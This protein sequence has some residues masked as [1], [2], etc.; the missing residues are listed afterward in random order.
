MGQCSGSMFA[1]TAAIALGATV[2]VLAGLFLGNLIPSSI[3][4]PSAELAN[5]HLKQFVFYHLWHWLPTLAYTVAAAL[6]G[7][8]GTL[9]YA[10]PSVA[11]AAGIG[12]FFPLS[13]ALSSMGTHLPYGFESALA[14]SVFGTAGAFMG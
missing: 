3:G 5:S 11:I 13:M 14:A 6:G 2:T 8:A 4:Y 7:M 10:V 1:K 9:A 12:T